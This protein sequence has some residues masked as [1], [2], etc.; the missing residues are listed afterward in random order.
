MKYRNLIICIILFFVG[1]IS[2]PYLK[3]TDLPKNVIYYS[4]DKQFSVKPEWY[5]RFRPE[6]DP[7]KYKSSVIGH[8]YLVN[9]NKDAVV[10]GEISNNSDKFFIVK[11]ADNGFFFIKEKDYNFAERYKKY[12]VPIDYLNYEIEFNDYYGDKILTSYFK[13]KLNIPSIVTDAY[14]FCEVDLYAYTTPGIKQ[15]FSGKY[16]NEFVKIE[17]CPDLLNLY[18]NNDI[19]IYRQYFV[20]T[21]PRKFQY[22]NSQGMVFIGTI[23]TPLF[24]IVN[25]GK[26]YYAL[27]YESNK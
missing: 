9:K 12:L 3:E 18:K 20:L 17:N 24:I 23:Y 14:P 26:V 7:L 5:W 13:S 6:S 10:I 19:N 16:T 1:C 11:W 4:E 8:K 21:A 15:R 27:P 2:S 22:T 25:W